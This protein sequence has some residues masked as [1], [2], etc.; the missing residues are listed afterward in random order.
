[1]SWQDVLLKDPAGASLI[2]NQAYSVNFIVAPAHWHK[3]NVPPLFTW[4]S[5][6]FDPAERVNVPKDPGLYAFIARIRVGSVPT[7]GWV[8]YIGQTG[9]G[10]SAGNLRTRFGHYLDN[11]DAVKG[12]HRI[13]FMLNNWDT[14]LD[15]F[16]APLP[17]RKNELTKLETDLLD[18]FR[19]PFTDRTYSATY[20]S[21]RH[22]F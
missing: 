18:A 16:F 15:F 8:M 1:M 9:D 4:Q 3:A 13:Y 19:P 10:T 12:R 6:Q 21:P 17:H 7:H 11:K 5:V 14:Y 22:A 2:D 20:L